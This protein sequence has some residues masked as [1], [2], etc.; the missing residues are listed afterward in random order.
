[1]LQPRPVCAATTRVMLLI[2]LASAVVSAYGQSQ[3]APS[4]QAAPSKVS[5]QAVAATTTTYEPQCKVEYQTV[6][7]TENVQVPV[8]RTETRYR[9]DYQTRTVPVTRWTV[10]LVWSDETA[11]VLAITFPLLSTISID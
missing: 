6:Y 7:D 4:G 9:T 11:D 10:K 5:D 8:T 3:N 1:M 2:A